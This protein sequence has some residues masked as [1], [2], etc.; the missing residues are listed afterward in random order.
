MF[1][2][3]AACVISFAACSGGST[4]S[5]N[6]GSSAGQPALPAVLTTPHSEITANH[7]E[8]PVS[9]STSP[10]TGG[11]HFPFWMNCGFYDEPV[12]EGA[13]T[14]SMEHGVVWITYGDSLAADQIELLRGLAAENSRLLISPYDHDEPIVLSAWG[15]Q[16]RAIP[17][18]TAPEIDAFISEWVDNP[19]LVEA[20]ASCST[21]VGNPPNDP[22][23]LVDGTPVPEEFLS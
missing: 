14:H 12:I 9:F 5:A 17:S 1:G 3:L 15:A 20:G 21:A 11:D 13:A 16:Q 10:S 23:S 18:A 4:T 6:N 2:V 19:E 7:V 22:N 8:P